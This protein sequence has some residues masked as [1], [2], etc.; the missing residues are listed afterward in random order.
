[1]KIERVI[2]HDEPAANN[3]FI[4]GQIQF[5]KVIDRLK[6]IRKNM[7]GCEGWAHAESLAR[8]VNEL[9]DIVNSMNYLLE[10]NK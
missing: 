5:D 7:R 8:N 9:I 3:A 6:Y 1:M 10:D 4:G 2:I